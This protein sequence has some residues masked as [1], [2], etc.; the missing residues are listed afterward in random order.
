M[1]KIEIKDL[2][3]VGERYESIDE[4]YKVNEE[5]GLNEHYSSDYSSGKGSRR[6]V[7]DGT[8]YTWDE[9]KHDMMMGSDLFDEEFGKALA[10]VEK[11]VPQAWKKGARSRARHDVVGQ[12][13][14]VER[15][16]SGHPKSFSRK[17]PV[18]MKQ[19]TI[20]FFFSIS[21]PWYTKT[22]D[23]LKAGC[24]LMAI[25]EHMER[26]GYQTRILYSPDFSAGRRDGASNPKWP[27]QLVQFTL[28]DFKTRFNLKKMQFP[29]ASESALFHVG[30]WWVH[31]A[32]MTTAD[33]GSGEGY[34]VDND[35]KRLENARE[36]ARRQDA[37]YLSIPFIKNECDMELM[38]VYDYVMK[39]MES[40]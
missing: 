32:P 31:R 8:R 38:K 40:M 13:V 3:I 25:C 14:C 35:P 15:A 36:Y 30:C 19:K 11:E 22:H 5:R 37:V 10:E 23:R 7:K 21:C 29:L 34:A 28:K 26:M 17:K 18:R 6:D 20:T 4:F 9:T 2:N 12:S 27:S 33:W 39:E 24:I 1:K 16:L